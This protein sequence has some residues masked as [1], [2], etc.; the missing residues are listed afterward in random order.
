MFRRYFIEDMAFL[1]LLVKELK[2]GDKVY[3]SDRGAGG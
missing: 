1:W 3:E 2:G